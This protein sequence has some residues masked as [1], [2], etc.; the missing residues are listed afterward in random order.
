MMTRFVDIN[1]DALHS[2]L[3]TLKRDDLMRF[4]KFIADLYD[5]NEFKKL[6]ETLTNSKR[7]NVAKIT[8]L[9]AAIEPIFK[10]QYF[11]EKIHNKLVSTDE[12]AFLYEQ[13]VWD[14]DK[15]DIS[16]LPA[17]IK[18]EPSTKKQQYGDVSEVL[19]P[20]PLSLINHF[21]FFRN[22]AVSMDY[23]TIIPSIKQLL[24]CVLKAPDELFLTPSQQVDP[25]EFE[26]N[27]EDGILSVINIIG[28]MTENNLIEMGTAE[29]PL[30]KTLNIVKTSAL[31]KEFYTTKGSE[32]LANDMLTRSFY[33]FYQQLGGYR[34]G[35]INILREFV[36]RQLNNESRFFISRIFMSH[37]KK[38]RF[39]PYYTSQESLFNTVGAVL[40]SM[41][42]DGFVSMENILTFC[43]KRDFWF[44][45]EGAAKTSDY[46]MSCDVSKGGT[47]LL[48]EKQPS[49]T[50]NVWV[51][52]E[53]YHAIFFEPIL[54]AALFYLGALGILELRYN[55]PTSKHNIKAEDKPYIS[56]W[57]G[58]EYVR[59]T[60]LGKFVLGF[61]A[62]YT[63][64]E[65]QQ[66]KAKLK[67]DEYSPIITIDA[68]DG[69]TIAKLE[70]YA[71]KIDANKYILSYSK[72][73]KDCDNYKALTLKIDGFY[74]QIASNPPKVFFDFFDKIK[75]RADLL[76]KESKLI[77]IKLKNNKELLE[78]FMT[79]KKLQEITVKA[80]GFRVLVLKDDILKL[81]KICSENG[82]FVEF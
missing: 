79:N 76:E 50:H 57:D 42:Q 14:K 52:K 47:D 46:Y 58:L 69:V 8:T 18:I 29:K 70:G 75:Q 7:R 1:Y 80:Q 21:V 36:T 56:V 59:F 44:Y 48:G 62:E 4:F 49:L 26:Y 43:K 53:N 60:D 68:K 74:K 22:G 24:L 11:R 30:V 5:E 72:I 33:F 77:T 34:G 23:L 82:F 66:N 9:I 13:L 63:P 45:L 81:K 35:E 55:A 15:I 16:A 27:N 10:D 71:D 12:S 25:T 67:F 38:V 40:F 28:E 73:F 3:E 32:L 6:D 51:Y 64:K 65:I 39:D 78:L 31:V 20:E 19:T 2:H 54:K 37:L 17:N 61:S 41:P